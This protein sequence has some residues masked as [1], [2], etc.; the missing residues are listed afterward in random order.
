MLTN[1]CR[2]QDA[3]GYKPGLTACIVGSVIIVL[4]VAVTDTHFYFA[5]KKQARGE[6][7]IEPV[8]GVESSVGLVLALIAC[9]F[10]TLTFSIGSV[11][12]Y[13]LKERLWPW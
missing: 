13:L 1:A 3:P 8:P 7:I 9:E 11:P 5:N 12:V 4:I 6:K 2:S 10:C